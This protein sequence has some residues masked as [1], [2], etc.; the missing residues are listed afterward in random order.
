MIRGFIFLALFTFWVQPEQKSY[1][2]NYFS[3]GTLQS[4][5]WMYQNQKVDYWFY[6]YENGNK[7]EE[8]H[9]KANKKEKW[10][11]FY[12]SNGQLIQKTEYK[13]NKP[14]GLS[15]LYKDETI[16]K[17]EKYKMGI[18]TNEWTSLSDFRKDNLE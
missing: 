8:G 4:E 1:A 12:N 9:Y 3:N 16:Y 6:Y 18:K 13:N 7:K 17:A 2:K 14:N 10:W 5:G 11:L 15:I